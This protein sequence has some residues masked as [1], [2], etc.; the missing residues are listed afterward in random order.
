MNP[1]CFHGLIVPKLYL[2][3]TRNTGNNLL[4][5]AKRA[6]EFRRLQA[7]VL[8]GPRP[9]PER[10]SQITARRKKPDS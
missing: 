2:A 5:G 1:S 6:K 10:N 9:R 4:A 3:G 7:T 8:R